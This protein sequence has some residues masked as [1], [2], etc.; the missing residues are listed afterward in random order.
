[1]EV[2][3]ATVTD[4]SQSR[5]L[6]LWE[7]NFRLLSLSLSVHKWSWKCLRSW[8]GWSAVDELIWP[9][10]PLRSERDDRI[11]CLSLDLIIFEE[12]SQS[13]EEKRSDC[14]SHLDCPFAGDICRMEGRIED[15]ID[16]AKL[17]IPLPIRLPIK[18]LDVWPSVLLLSANLPEKKTRSLPNDGFAPC[19]FL[20]P[21]RT[22]RKAFALKGSSMT[23]GGWLLFRFVL[24]SSSIP[25]R[26]AD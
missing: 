15:Q 14:L 21:N 13:R 18:W 1:M 24:S 20:S 26:S 19:T 17:L 4:R 5:P 16:L 22:S 10:L 2:E 3:W 9:P 7:E 25:W 11:V 6:S 23:R 8:W 12:I